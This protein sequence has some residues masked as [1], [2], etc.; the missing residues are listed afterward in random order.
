[1]YSVHA[2]YFLLHI[3]AKFMQLNSLQNFT[4]KKYVTRSILF[5]IYFIHFLAN[6]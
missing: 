3:D 4:K 2:Q 5:I 1:M 6:Y